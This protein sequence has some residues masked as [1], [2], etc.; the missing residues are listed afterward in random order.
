MSENKILIVFLVVW[1]LVGMLALARAASGPAK[2]NGS[3]RRQS[4][5]IQQKSGGF[6]AQ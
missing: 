4:E 5:R 3:F 6:V 1:G 2:I